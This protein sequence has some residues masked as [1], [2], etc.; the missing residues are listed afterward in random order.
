MDRKKGFSL[1]EMLVVIGIIAVLSGALLVG[2][3]RIRRTAQ[4]SKAQEIVSNTATALGTIFQ[5]EMAWPKALISYNNRQLEAA[6]SH[7]F[8]RHGLLGLSYKKVS[9]KVT[10]TGADRCGI[11]DPWAAAALKRKKASES[12]NE[13]IGL[14]VDTGGKVRD[15]ILWYA[16]DDDGDGI[17]KVQHPKDGIISVRAPACVWSAG[18]DGVLGSMKRREKASDDDVYSWSRQQEVR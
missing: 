8:V 7:V 10:L 5:K 12:E 14:N 4:R 9:G 11:V 2:M 13:D 18:A 17:T 15:H 16:I 3:D 1:I 6:P